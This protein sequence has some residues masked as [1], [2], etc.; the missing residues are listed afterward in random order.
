[1]SGIY[2]PMT[3]FIHFLR[4]LLTMFDKDIKLIGRLETKLLNSER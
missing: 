3:N 2:L 4:A 1:M